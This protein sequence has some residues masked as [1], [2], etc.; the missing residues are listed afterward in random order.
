MLFH[1]T[2]KY[3]IIRRDAARRF[4]LVLSNQF[5]RTASTIAPASTSQ[6][7]PALAATQS[8][9][10]LAVLNIDTGRF[11]PTTRSLSYRRVCRGRQ[12]NARNMGPFF[13]TSCTI[14]AR[15]SKPR[16]LRRAL[17]KRR[18][19]KPLRGSSLRR[20]P[21]DRRQHPA[22]LKSFV[23]IASSRCDLQ[24]SSDLIVA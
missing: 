3:L 5:L 8:G 17:R 22:F 11:R 10:A 12:T 15:P 21:K 7:L 23:A 1:R 9:R 16:R 14:M 2:N 24:G 4:G 13:M 18:C 19:T 6:P 20:G